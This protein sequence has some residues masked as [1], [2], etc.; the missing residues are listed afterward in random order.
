MKL[1]DDILES[2]ISE[3][4]DS[5][6]KPY[7]Y[8]KNHLW[9]HELIKYSLITSFIY[10]ILFH[11]I[12]IA[13]FTEK[14]G[15]LFIHNF[16]K[17]KTVLLDDIEFNFW[18]NWSIS[19]IF[20][21]LF[22]CLFSL[23][24]IYFKS[25]KKKMV[26]THL[27]RF[28]NSFI[29]R[30]ELNNY[31]LNNND[32]HLEKAA[33]YFSQINIPLQNIILNPEN[34]RENQL[35][36]YDEL[37]K[38]LKQQSDF[39]ELTNESIRKISLLNQIEDKVVKRLKNKKEIEKITPLINYLT[40]YEYSR[41]KPNDLNEDNIKIKNYRINYLD[42]FFEKLEELDK[43]ELNIEEEI[44][45]NRFIVIFQSIYRFFSSSN[46]ISLFLAWYILLTVIIISTT[47]LIVNI[48]NFKIDSAIIIGIISTPFVC[49]ITITA[50][51][52]NKK[53]K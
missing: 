20:S 50:A 34:S 28:C 11:L 13:P 16:I 15:T 26:Q 14:E 3:F 39:V 1:K 30:K 32:S 45:K 52:I 10:L 41:I 19:I 4:Y 47:I 40:L 21:F 44:K 49:A 35:I 46:S 42:V 29:L 31:L 38:R 5:I 53:Y 8:R 43:L 25:R 36:S 12:P 2:R 37:K 51:Y 9:I 33:Y 18:V 6:E 48:F 22:F 17:N 23:I 7:T 24:N 27:L